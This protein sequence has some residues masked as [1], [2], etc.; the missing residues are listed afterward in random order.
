MVTLL[1]DSPNFLMD[2]AT[3]P[4]GLLSSLRWTEEAHEDEPVI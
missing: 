3:S 4:D 1:F 2:H